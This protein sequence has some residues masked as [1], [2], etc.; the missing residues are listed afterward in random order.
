M[1]RVFVI[2]I[3][4]HVIDEDKKLEK[5]LRDFS[6]IREPKI[7]IH[8]GGGIATRI[9]EALN[10]Q[11]QYIKGRRVTDAKTLD[12]VTMVYGGLI[13]KQITARLQHLGVN[14]MGITG[15]DGN[16]IKAVKRPVGE[17]DF[18]FVGDLSDDAVN[19]TLLFT[20]LKQN[21]IPV[22]A[23]LTHGEGHILNTN[24][25]TIASFISIAMSKHFDVRLVYCF[26]KKGIL[27]DVEKPGSVISTLNLP[28]YK[29]LLEDGA[30]HDGILPK[31]EGAF[32]AIRSGVKEV[33]IGD[34]MDLT[35]NL[36]AETT[37]TLITL[38]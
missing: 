2:K 33:V 12:L 16:M 24:A 17:V 27:E 13:N 19:D 14:A 32:N 23:P 10:I 20:L 35:D 7:L 11:P 25:D 1:N 8:G 30:L 29:K 26:E 38:Y 4:G 31:I 6:T 36:G 3:G 18:G 5:F 34:A 21:I 22:F 9:G 28:K 37:G 15:A